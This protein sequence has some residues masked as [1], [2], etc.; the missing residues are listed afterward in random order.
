[1]NDLN[2]NG[3]AIPQASTIIP[4][5]PKLKL[6]LYQ[7]RTLQAIHA[8][9]IML[10]GRYDRYFWNDSDQLCSAV[11]RRLKS[12]GLIKTVY[13]NSVRDKVE[14][15]PAGRQ[16]V[17]GGVVWSLFDG[18]GLMG[19]PWAE[20]G[21]HV[22]CFNADSANHGEYII[23]MQ[24]ENLHYVDMWIDKDFVFNMSSRQD[25][26]RPSIIFGFPDCTM[27]AVSGAK[28]ERTKDELDYALEMA[29]AVKHAGESYGVP[30][31]IEN[32]VGKLCRP[33]MMGK[34]NAYFDPFEYGAFMT[35][36]DK[37]FH[38]KMPKFDGYTKKTCLWFDNGFQMPDKQPGPINIGLF[39]GWKWLG[40]KSTKT[41]QLRS[42]TP[43]GFARAVFL[44]NH[45]GVKPYG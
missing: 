28:K 8:G 26:P 45:Q 42:L 12:K 13:L 30:W 31:M 14:L 36:S 40:G 25:I 35:D 27:F 16:A 18:S 9:K 37:P 17:T 44:A 22:Y 34:P 20:A 24:H 4:P 32:P 21:Y 23:K 3:I 29:K 39:W 15:T 38:P 7:R 1:M 19:L 6:T 41:K 11:A 5:V 43:R 2:V 33:D 10:R